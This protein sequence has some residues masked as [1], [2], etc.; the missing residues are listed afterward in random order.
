MLWALAS[1]WKVA[2]AAPLP[3]VSDVSTEADGPATFQKVFDATGMSKEAIYGAGRQWIAENFR[4]SKAVIEYEDVAEGVII[5]QA[6][7]PYPCAS[8]MECLGKPDWTVRFTMRME[9]REGRFRL[10][11]TNVRLH[12][13]AK[14]N[15]GVAQPEFEGA[16]RRERDL[17]KIRPKL[18]AFGAGIQSKL[19]N[20][21]ASNEW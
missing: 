21:A 8:A 10:T 3:S 6:N 16:V 12:W 19:A 9:A 5:G 11:F 2:N 14:V 15:A 18:E 4:S 1:C 7:M 20:R 13:P 17:E